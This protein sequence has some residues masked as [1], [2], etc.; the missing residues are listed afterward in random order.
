MLKD[1]LLQVQKPARYIGQE[2]NLP[3]KEFDKARIKFALC[4]PD[5]YEIGMSNLGIRVLYSILNNIPDVVCERFFSPARDME[6]ALRANKMSVFSLESARNLREFDIIG[7]SLGHELSYTNVLNL[8]DL[9]GIPLKSSLR[10]A[11]HPLI[12]GGG[13]CALN[14]E[15]MH[16]FFDLFLIGEAE[17]A[18]LEIIDV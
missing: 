1:I 5:L 7:F 16:E 8:L 17:E 4:F 12:I 13:P 3:R 11:D 15:P 2:W 6:L 18:I 9:G 10:S 14:P